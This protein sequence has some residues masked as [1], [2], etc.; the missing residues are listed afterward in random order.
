MSTLSTPLSSPRLSTLAAYSLSIL[1]SLLMLVTK[2]VIFHASAV[3][4]WYLLFAAAVIV[5]TWIGGLRP[6][7]VSLILLGV[8]DLAAA[9]L[10]GQAINLGDWV[11]FVLVAGL[12]VAALQRHKGII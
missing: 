4:S 2:W 1:V 8:G 10:Q 5:L 12:A 6:G 7:L 11:L 9:A 3:E